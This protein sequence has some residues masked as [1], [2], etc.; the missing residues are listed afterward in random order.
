MSSLNDMRLYISAL[1]VPNYY[2]LRVDFSQLDLRQIECRESYRETYNLWCY[3]KANVI[4][5]IITSNIYPNAKF[6]VTIR[7]IPF[8]LIHQL[9]LKNDCH[10][11]FLELCNYCTLVSDLT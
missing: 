5:K 11:P 2:H 8:G 6:L 1:T 7:D 9:N 10:N 3:H 4:H